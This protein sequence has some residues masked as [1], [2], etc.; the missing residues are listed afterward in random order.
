[1]ANKIVALILWF[2]VGFI[3]HLAFIGSSLDP[4]LVSTWLFILL[5]PLIIAGMVLLLVAPLGAF[6]AC[7]YLVVG[8]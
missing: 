4:S 7:L 5:W 1:M 6:L 8:E 3:L 2:A